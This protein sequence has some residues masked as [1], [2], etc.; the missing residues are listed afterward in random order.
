[1]LVIG[2][3]SGLKTAETLPGVANNRALSFESVIA[4][5]SA[6][7]ASLETIILTTAKNMAKPSRNEMS[8]MTVTRQPRR[9]L[10][11]L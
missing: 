6:L 3:R 1:M 7:R 11:E 8:K 9:Q 4:R 5:Y 10:P 2:S